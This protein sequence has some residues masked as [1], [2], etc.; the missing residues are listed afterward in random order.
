LRER[1]FYQLAGPISDD[2]RQQ[3]SS[4]AETLGVKLNIA[5]ALS[6]SDLVSEI[7][8]ADVM[9]CLRNPVLEG[10]SA[11]AI[12]AMLAGR[13]LFVVDHGFYR[14]L[15]DDLTIKL[16]P[17]FETE[18][19][20]AQICRLVSHPEECRQMGEG[21]AVWARNVFSFEKYAKDFIE[22][23]EKSIESKPLLGLA[24][25]LGRELAA[26]GV[27]P[28]D[29]AAARMAQQVSALFLPGGILCQPN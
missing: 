18:V 8:N 22:L 23:A 3:L 20:S 1:C 7:E 4:L 16:A 5:G 13:P 17:D 14:D 21:A 29:P 19:L 26:L 2:M 15:P 27:Q 6:K 12:E 28:E 11:S 25:D 9:M 24:A 10:A